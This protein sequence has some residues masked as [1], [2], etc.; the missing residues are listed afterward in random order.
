MESKGSVV[1]IGG[2]SEIGKGIAKHYA[3]QGYP[4]VLTSR[5]KERADAAAADISDNSRGLALDLTDPHSVEGA[6]ESVQD[7]QYAAVLSV[8]RDENTMENYNIDSAMQLVIMKMI[9]YPEVSRVLSD[10]MRPGGA[11][12]LYGGYAK[13]RPYPGSTTVTSVNGGVEA[14]TRT[15]GVQLAPVRINA[16][17]LAVVGDSPYWRDKPAS[18]MDTLRG[19]TALG[20][21]PT[22]EDAVHATV[23]LLE[24]KAAT[25]L[26]MRLDSGSLLK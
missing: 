8:L 6:L 13:D 23:F 25:G 15:L 2:T 16:L 12:V 7:V 10:R 9:G 11:I 24:N 4:I 5:S 14:M 22:I 1:I 3:E 21:L 19:R 26:N 20:E 18:V 17:H